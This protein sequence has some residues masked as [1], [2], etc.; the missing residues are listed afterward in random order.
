MKMCK[1]S[2]GAIVQAKDNTVYEITAINLSIRPYIL[3]G[4]PLPSGEER[5]LK[6][7]DLK[8]IL[9]DSHILDTL[10]DTL[11]SITTTLI[12]ILF[13]TVM[14]SLVAKTLKTPSLSV[15]ISYVRGLL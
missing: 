1:L 11:P 15:P 9:K 3:K 10:F 5:V 7:K 2:K 13:T 8:L 14:L 4:K 12:P 6:F